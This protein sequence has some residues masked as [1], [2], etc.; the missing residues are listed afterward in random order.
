VVSAER[1]LERTDALL[2][3][4][5]LRLHTDG[6]ADAPLNAHRFGRLRAQRDAAAALLAIDG[7]ADETRAFLHDLLAEIRRFLPDTWPEGMADVVPDYL[8]IGRVY[9]IEGRKL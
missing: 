8:S 6:V 4:L 3:K 7:A 2:S 5:A 9:L 1:Y